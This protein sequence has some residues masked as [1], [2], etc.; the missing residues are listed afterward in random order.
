M[1]NYNSLNMVDIEIEG[2]LSIAQSVFNCLAKPGR[3]HTMV[4]LMQNPE[5]LIASKIK[6]GL[7]EM[8]NRPNI[9][10]STVAN[11]INDL[12]DADLVANPEGRHYGSRRLGGRYVATDFGRV[13]F[14]GY[15]ELARRLGSIR[16]EAHITRLIAGLS[17]RE[18]DQLIKLAQGKLEAKPVD[19]KFP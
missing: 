3:K 5:G 19:L 12:S 11:Y 7:Q 2:A 16:G 15:V 13:A 17:P 14:Q 6:T 10:A 18:L 4:L 8:L 9:P 1:F